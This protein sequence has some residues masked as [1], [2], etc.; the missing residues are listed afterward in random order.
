M[1]AKFLFRVVFVV[2]I[3]NIFIFFF[4]NEEQF[5]KIKKILTFSVNVEKRMELWGRV[6]WRRGEGERKVNRK[7]LL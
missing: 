7:E 4:F 1:Q 5:M 3:L 2:H 6:A